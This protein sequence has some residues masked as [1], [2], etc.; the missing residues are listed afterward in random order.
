VRAVLV[1][2][3][4]HP[5]RVSA[6]TITPDQGGAPDRWSDWLLARRQGG[7]DLDPDLSAELR[8]YRDGVLAGAEL[9]SRD[10]L[11]DVGCGDGLIGFGALEA[12]GRDLRVVFSD[13]SG[14]LLRR[15]KKRA[16]EMGVAERCAFVESRAEDLVDVGDQSVDVVTT[17]SVLIY[18]ERKHIALA[19]FFRV[20]RPGGRISL[21]EPINRRMYPEPPELFWGWDVSTVPELRNK[22]VAEVERASQSGWRAMMNFDD[23]D[24]VRLAEGAGFDAVDLLMHVS[25]NR[26]APRDWERVLHSSPNPLAPTLAEA[27]A[28]SLDDRQADRF[29]KALRTSVEAGVGRSRL[30]I[31]YLR[32]RKIEGGS[33]RT[34][35]M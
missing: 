8:R 32:A 1:L 3:F 18:V 29:L 33:G 14:E 34:S 22:V 13:V 7:H 27:V 26:P 10:V 16:A 12:H 31:A 24:L 20:L 17:R 21:M 25:V 23:H 28:G 30:A 9:Q 35:Q 2:A 19:E 15:C 11:L 5:V 6:H 4:G